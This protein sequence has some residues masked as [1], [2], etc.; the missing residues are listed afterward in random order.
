MRNKRI[1]EGMSLRFRRAGLKTCHYKQNELILFEFYTE[2]WLYNSVSEII[3]T[4]GGWGLD[5]ASFKPTYDLPPTHTRKKNKED[6][7]SRM[8]AK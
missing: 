6:K 8:Q 3:L 7:H 1:G 2:I 5:P 4:S